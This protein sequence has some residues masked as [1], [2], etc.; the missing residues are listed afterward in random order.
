VT[1]YRCFPWD[2]RVEA[3]TRGGP[4]WFPRMLQG[5]GRHDNP[6]LYGCIYATETSVSAV[7]ERLQGLRGAQLEPE[8]LRSRGFPLGLAALR[9]A[10]DAGVVDLDEPRVLGEE[11]LR[12]SLVATNERPRTQADAAALYER[13]PDAAGIRWW[14][15]FESQWA[16]VTLFDRATSEL[17]VADIQPL[18]LD[19][20]VVSEAARFLGLALAA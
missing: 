20:D 7:V 11:G 3:G 16:N 6:G 5:S 19:D 13:H 4:L 8:D 2:A 18:A 15:T 9:L 12:P 14:S 10:D 1:L 17:A